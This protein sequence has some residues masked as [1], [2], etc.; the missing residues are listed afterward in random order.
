MSIMSPK[1][2]VVPSNL[3]KKKVVSA[4]M[5]SYETGINIRFVL[6]VLVINPL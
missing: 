2:T 1:Q 3:K 5:E 6:A 4:T